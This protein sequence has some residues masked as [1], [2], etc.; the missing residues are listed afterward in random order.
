MRKLHDAPAT[1]LFMHHSTP[2][3]LED[4]DHAGIDPGSQR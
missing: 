4:L 2:I 1:S 3:E